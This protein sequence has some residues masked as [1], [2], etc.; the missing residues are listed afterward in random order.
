MEKIRVG[1]VGL[2]ANCHL[3][4]VPGLRRCQDVE[5]TGVVNR[6]A[7]STRAAADKYGIPKTY[8]HWE[9]LVADSDIDAVVIGTWPYLHC[10]IT[11]AGLEAGKHVLTEARMA[12]SAVE[13]R[14]MYA[15]SQQHPELVTQV[16]PSPFGFSGL[17]VIREMVEAG[18]L[19]ELREVAALSVNHFL[20]DKETPLHWRQVREF[21]GVNVLSLG[22]LHEAVSRWVP[23]AERVLAQTQTFTSRRLNTETNEMAE[24]EIP[25]SVQVLGELPGGARSI[26]HV[27]GAIHHGPGDQIHL[28]GSEGTIKYS[29]SPEDKIFAASQGDSELREVTIPPEKKY[30]WRVEEDFIDAIRGEGEIRLTD[31]ATGVAYMEFTEAVAQSAASGASVEVSGC[32]T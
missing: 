29:V 9:Q 20:A 4:H 6:R 8:D 7:E 22:I 12:A 10:P 25:D 13:A 23:A 2:G 27:S 19:G 26:Y 24:A 21:S 5:I 28:Y 14:K 1:I 31:F 15:A 17:H 3:Q 11:L 18:F 30:S 32:G 16:V